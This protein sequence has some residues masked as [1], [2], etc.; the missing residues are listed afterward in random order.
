MNYDPGLQAMLA[1]QRA[2]PIFEAVTDAPNLE[3]VFLQL[4]ATP[5]EV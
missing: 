2:I 1:A 3:D 4:T 5:K